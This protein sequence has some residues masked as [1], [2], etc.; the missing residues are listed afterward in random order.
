MDAF[1]HGKR[2]LL[3]VTGGIAAIK[4]PEIARRAREAGAEVRCVLTEG[5]AQFITPLALETLTGGA[6][7]T[8]LWDSHPG[9][10]P[11]HID[12]ARES[13]V[14]LIAPATA[15]FLAKMAHGLA[16]DLAGS[17]LLAAEIPVVVAPAMNPV[18]W[19]HP[20]TRANVALL[21]ERGVTFLGPDTGAMACHEEGPGRMMDPAAIVAALA[22]LP[23]NGEGVQR[24]KGVRALVTSGPTHEPLD[25]VRF[26]GNR[27]S[28][29][30]GHAIAAALAQQG[31]EVILVTGPTALPDPIG[32]AV[33]RVQTADEMLAA[34]CQAL[35]V[36]VAVCAA[37][38]ADW[39]PEAPA[40]L[41]MKKDASA[42]PP[43]LTLVPTPDI[44]AALA[45]GRAGPRPRL[46]V[47]FA[48]ETGNL[49]A[50]AEAKLAAKGCD[51]LVANDV[52][53]GA[54]FGQDTNEITLVRRAAP[55]L[56]PTV[57]TWPRLTKTEVA[58][59]LAERLREGLEM[60]LLA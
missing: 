42:T 13:D 32:V 10:K 31:T 14:I 46:V 9:R 25:P 16:E 3:I 44:L 29:K 59:R 2:L 41:K 55:G 19:N 5:G 20:A 35:P 7:F 54:V 17:L 45:S 4:S 18:M 21:R 57:E 8:N 24:L 22:T 60:S 36:D 6:V 28:G 51:W 38:V 11:L 40:S 1:L 37:A 58:E 12:L 53:A 39:R 43:A 33:V 27:S 52:S 30:Q 48:A 23:N 34:C 15:H 26:L 56:P 50:K 49:R 47:G